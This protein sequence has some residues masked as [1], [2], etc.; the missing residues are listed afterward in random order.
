MVDLNIQ[1]PE[2]FL[3]EEIRCDY[4][5][6]HEMKKAW[7]VMLDLLAEFDRVCQK[8]NIKYFASGGTMLGA[9]RHKGFIPWD[10]DIDVMME[11]SDYEKLCIVGPTEFK[12]PYFL[13][14]KYTDPECP[15]IMSK[16]RNSETTAFSAVEEHGFMKY[17]KGIFMDIFPLD[18]IPEDKKEQD[19]FYSELDLEIHK[20]YRVGRRYGI[21]SEDSSITTRYLKKLLHYLLKWRRKYFMEGYLKACK[22]YDMLCQKFNNQ[23]S[24]YFSTIQFRLDKKD[25]KYKSDYKDTILMDFEFLKI[26]VGKKYDHGLCVRFGEN[27]ME[28]V[29]GASCHSGLFFDT[30]KAYKEYTNS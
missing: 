30:D 3:D 16:L 10:D 17:N 23:E 24:P 9:V 15:N 7:A 27:Y 11:R 26:P 14:N 25:I 8:H 28:F 12:Y 29:K 22:S 20:M 21:F 18:N 1:L 6:T 2:G 19:S 13:Q 4:L 5:V